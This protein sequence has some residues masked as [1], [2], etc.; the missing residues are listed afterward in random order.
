MPDP[1][2]LQSPEDAKLFVLARSTR[3]RTGASEA[4]ALRDSAV[5]LS[6]VEVQHAETRVAQPGCARQDGIEHRA[7]VGRRAA[8]NAQDLAACG[9][10]LQRF[11]RLVEQPRV[12]DGDDRLRGK[13]LQ[14]L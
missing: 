9:L 12:L 6:F 2:S 7:K 11:L 1:E 10:L 4:A 5:L 3:G 8:D 13:R 14:Q